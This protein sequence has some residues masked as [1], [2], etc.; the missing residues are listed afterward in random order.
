MSLLVGKL[1][2]V[3]GETAL[4]LLFAVATTYFTAWVENKLQ[5]TSD[6]RQKT[7]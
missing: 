1:G 5:G 3:V 4:K 6:K 2:K 7:T